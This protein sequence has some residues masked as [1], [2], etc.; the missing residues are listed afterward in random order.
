MKVS[1]QSMLLARMIS[2]AFEL[3]EL[4]DFRLFFEDGHCLEWHLSA[5]S[6]QPLIP[7]QV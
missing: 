3:G 5:R 2:S 1:T 7:A 6:D 4:N